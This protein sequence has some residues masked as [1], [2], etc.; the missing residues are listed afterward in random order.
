[1]AKRTDEQDSPAQA[2]SVGSDYWSQSRRPLA[3]LFFAGP[4]L[5]VYETG[6]ICLGPGAMRNG[7]DAWLRQTLDLLGFN[8]YFLLPTLTVGILLGWH[9]VL[10]QP[11]SVPRSVL[12][13]MAGESFALAVGLWLSWKLYRFLLQTVV[14]TVGLSVADFLGPIFCYLGAG[15]YEELLFRLILL[16]LGIGLLAWMR[17]GPRASV[18]GGIVLTSLLFSAAHYV[19]TSGDSFLWLTFFF[20]FLAGVLFAVLF[21]YRGFGIAAGTHAFYDVLVGLSPIAG[22]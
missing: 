4:L 9:H 12:Y 16:N 2:P 20:R 6:L 3:S 13:R 19:G 5:V 21:R 7:A 15:I 11:W 17:A 8:A 22:R 10:R 14:H 18:I 1:M